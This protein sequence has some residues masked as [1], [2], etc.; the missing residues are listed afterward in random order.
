MFSL[1]DSCTKV[2]HRMKSRVST[3]CQLLCLYGGGT[4]HQVELLGICLRDV[5]CCKQVREEGVSAALF[6][7]GNWAIFII[8]VNLD[9]PDCVSIANAYHSWWDMIRDKA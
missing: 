4:H 6:L 9:D 2:R 7:G 8:G 5:L 1:Y 3:G